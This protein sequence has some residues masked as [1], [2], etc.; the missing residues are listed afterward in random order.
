MSDEGLVDERPP[1]PAKQFLGKV[2]VWLPPVAVGGLALT[3]CTY[4]ALVDPSTAQGS[5]FPQ[6]TFKALT[7][8]D[9]PGCGLTRA[10]HA[11]L[12]GHP[13]AALDHNIFIAVIF[14][15]AAYMYVRWLG[16]A[17]FGWKLP[18]VRIPRHIGWA[19]VPA[20]LA[21]WVVR[22]IPVTPFTW[23]ASGA[24]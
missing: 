10:M 21:F 6:C 3:A 17:L 7:G 2:P 8:L 18:G 19:L 1:P 11:L 24:G 23:L 13:V 16:D 14:P 9:C 12:T 5:V 15:L 22:N 20:L 4:V